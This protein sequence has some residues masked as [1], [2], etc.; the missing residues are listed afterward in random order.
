MRTDP[1]LGLPVKSTLMFVLPQLLFHRP[2]AFLFCH[3]GLMFLQR[4]GQAIEELSF[5]LLVLI[6]SML[7]LLNCQMQLPCLFFS[8]K[9]LLFLLEIVDF[10]I[11]DQILDDI[12]DLPRSVH[13]S[14]WPC[15]QAI[16]RQWARRHIKRQIKLRPDLRAINASHRIVC[17]AAYHLGFSDNGYDIQYDSMATVK[18]V[19]VFLMQTNLSHSLLTF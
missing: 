4:R 11:V 6:H 7:L 15:G 1:L 3:K 19:A 5:L 13:S 10:W 12:P 14:D 8:R 18:S 17:P 2:L 9:L 16:R